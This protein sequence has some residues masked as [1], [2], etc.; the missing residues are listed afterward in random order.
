M[1]PHWWQIFREKRG[2]GMSK[3]RSHSTSMNPLP[4]ILGIEQEKLRYWSSSCS[5]TLSISSINSWVASLTRYFPSSA[6]SNLEKEMRE[7]QIKKFHT[8]IKSKIHM[9]FNITS[10]YHCQEWCNMQ[11]RRWRS[12]PCGWPRQ[13]KAFN[14][15]LSFLRHRYCNRFDA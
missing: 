14:Q 7:T 3:I 15:K 11:L 1:L 8:E 13:V 12:I 5:F 2:Y 4:V 9:Q 6:Q 10:E